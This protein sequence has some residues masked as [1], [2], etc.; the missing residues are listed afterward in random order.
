MKDYK[1][2]LIK[3]EEYY[4]VIFMPKLSDEQKMDLEGYLTFEDYQIK[5]HPAKMDLQRNFTTTFLI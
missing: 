2:I 4:I 3:I 1:E 5:N